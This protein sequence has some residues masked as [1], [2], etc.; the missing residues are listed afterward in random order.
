MKIINILFAV[1][2]AGRFGQRRR[3]RHFHN[4]KR[5]QKQVAPTNRAMK[6]VDGQLYAQ[7]VSSEHDDSADFSYHKMDSIKDLNP[8]NLYTQNLVY[9]W[10]VYQGEIDIGRPTIGPRPTSSL[11]STVHPDSIQIGKW[12]KQIINQ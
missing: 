7:E 6:L 2:I 5:A 3:F 1:A 11:H 4:H 10:V 12:P 9:Q 8:M